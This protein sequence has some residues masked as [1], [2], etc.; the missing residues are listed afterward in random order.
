M[1]TLV[2]L[3]GAL[4]CS[5]HW[6][7]VTELL[8]GD[9]EIH[10]PDFPEHGNGKVHTGSY[11]LSD[12]TRFIEDYVSENELRDYILIGY[13]M[14][15][16]AALK[17]ASGK[18]QHLKGLITIA[19]KMNW[20]ETIAENEIANINQEK[21]Q[22]IL[23]KLQS[24]HGSNWPALIGNTHSILRSIGKSPLSN[25]ELCGIDVPLFVLRGER[26][27]MVS[28]EECSMLSEIVSG[29]E[30]M[31]LEGQGHLLERMDA[32][33]LAEKLRNLILKL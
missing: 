19:T 8:S 23:L 11:T 3:H 28:A 7:S 16:Y 14:G 31:E 4:G 5:S 24:E 15:G 25:E 12:L 1:R 26:D 13:S 33:L 30:Y 6:R 18:P 20:S 27:K 21:L 9:F 10:C 32:V 17:F 22:P 29:S 2:F